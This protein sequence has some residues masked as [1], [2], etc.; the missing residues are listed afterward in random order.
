V[1]AFRVSIAG[2]MLIIALLAVDCAVVAALRGVT[3]GIRVAFLGAL[4]MANLAAA[5][6]ALAVSRLARRGEVALPLVTFAL[7]GGAAILLLLATANLAP[8]FFFEYLDL[9]AGFY[10]GPRQHAV[11]VHLFGMVRTGWLAFLLVHSAVTAPLLIPALLGSWMT[12]GY[13]LRLVMGSEGDATPVH[14]AGRS[15]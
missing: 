14:D 3:P 5:C 2:I 4:P 13:R 9:T 10:R 8:G 1:R 15:R 11:E 6:L 7:V 12:R